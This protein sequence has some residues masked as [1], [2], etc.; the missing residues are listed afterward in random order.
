MATE[1]IFSSSLWSDD[2]PPELAGL[3][4]RRLPSLADRVR[5]GAVCRHWSLAA[6]QQA[7]TLPPA[8]P[9]ISGFCHNQVFVAVC[10]LR[11]YPGSAPLSFPSQVFQSFPDGESH[12][13]GL[14]TSSQSTPNMVCCG[15]SDNWLMLMSSVQ[16]VNLLKNPL[17]G[18]TI[19]LPGNC[20]SG[21]AF[22][23]EVIQKFIVCSD[24]GLTVAMATTDSPGYEDIA[25][26][27]GNIYGVTKKG[28]LYKHD[29]GE[30]SGTGEPVV[31]YAKQVITCGD[32]W[33]DLARKQLFLVVSRGDLMLVKRNDTRSRYGRTSKPSAFEVF[34]ADLEMSRWSEVSSLGDQVLFVSG[35]CSRAVSASS[36][37]G[38]YLRG[39]RIYFTHHEIYCDTDHSRLCA[40]K[41]GVYDLRG[42]PT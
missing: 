21:H 33:F 31:S 7:P 2:L 3:A 10:H 25:F 5:F 42:T 18:A 27:H 22:D 26:H 29:I 11:L 38:N 36:H 23:C 16:Q 20:R 39:D 13:L 17:S 30:D 37:Y 32:T 19:P 41:S 12:N 34:K 8:L 14:G 4:L 9:W 6:Q 28:D 1:A 15:L 40:T 35:M 24:D